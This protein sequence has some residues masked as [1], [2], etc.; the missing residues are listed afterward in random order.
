MSDD[1]VDVAKKRLFRFA[2]WT[3]WVC[4]LFVLCV[5][6]FF[7]APRFSL[8]YADAQEAIPGLTSFVI[9]LSNVAVGSPMTAML[10]F[11]LMSV[12]FG[13]CTQLVQ[14]RDSKSLYV[15]VAFFASLYIPIFSQ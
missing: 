6:V 8:L 3:G 10:S 14:R 2:A 11:L 4:T 12:I 13:V 7:V 5:Q 15:S 9:Q 1:R